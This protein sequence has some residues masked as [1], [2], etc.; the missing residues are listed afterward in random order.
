[1]FLEHVNL[2][3]NDVDRSADFYSKV[4]GFHR[5]WEGAGGLGGRTVH[6]GTDTT[7]LALWQPTRAP[8]GGFDFDR[9]GNGFNHIGIVVDDLDEVESRLHD[10]GVETFNHGDYEP[11]RRFYFEDPDEIE[12]E[13][14]S[15]AS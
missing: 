7:Y 10:L 6:V 1:M 12:V 8:E 15:Y 5:R 9:R 14:V 13:V 4:F 2:T 3:V 11:G